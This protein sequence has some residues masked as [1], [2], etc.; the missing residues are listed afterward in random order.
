MRSV[1]NKTA[2]FTCSNAQINFD[3]LLDLTFFKDSDGFYYEYTLFTLGEYLRSGYVDK[4]YQ[5]RR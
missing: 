4:F 1:F 5:S 2:T 3:M